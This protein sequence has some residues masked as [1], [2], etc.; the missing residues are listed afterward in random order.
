MA[1]F[2]C[3]DMMT[4][5]FKTIYSERGSSQRV[6]EEITFMLFLELLQDCEG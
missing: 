4:K 1:Y 5:M 2:L 6:K 3:I